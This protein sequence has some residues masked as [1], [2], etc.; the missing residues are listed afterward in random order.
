VPRGLSVACSTPEA[1]SWDPEWKNIHEISGRAVGVHVASAEFDA[2][3]HSKEIPIPKAN[4]LVGRRHLAPS[5]PDVLSSA[6]PADRVLG[7]SPA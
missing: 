3:A 4:G 5:H 2:N 1:V 7:L 6:S